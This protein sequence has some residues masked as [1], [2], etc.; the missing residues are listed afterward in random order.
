[1]KQQSK[2]SI[3]EKPESSVQHIPL[4]VFG[5]ECVDV[6]ED[7]RKDVCIAILNLA[8]V[9]QWARRDAAVQAKRDRN[10]GVIQAPPVV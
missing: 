4:P 6:C 9:N 5:S 2:C 3:C 10:S 8:M 7:C 1:M